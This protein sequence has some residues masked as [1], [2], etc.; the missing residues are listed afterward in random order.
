ME[1][2]EAGVVTA[3]R[4]EAVAVEV[5]AAVKGVGLMEV[6]VDMAAVAG[7]EVALGVMVE[8]EGMGIEEVVVEGA[9]PAPHRGSLSPKNLP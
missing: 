2:E 6:V 1:K 8:A 7:E 4:G 5:M 9:G 3:A